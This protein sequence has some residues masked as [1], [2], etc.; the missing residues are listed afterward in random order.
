MRLLKAD[1]ALRLLPEFGA[2]RHCLIVL[3]YIRAWKQTHF[4]TIG[5][6]CL[7]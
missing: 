3:D 7:T 6:C 2:R 5:E 1:V 4:A